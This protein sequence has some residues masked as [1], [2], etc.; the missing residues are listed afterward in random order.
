MAAMNRSQTLLLFVFV[1]LACSAQTIQGN[2]QNGTTGKP[3]P[4]QVKLFTTSG[5]L[6]S[7]TTDD[8]GMFRI[9]LSGNLAPRSLAILKVIHDG[10]EYFQAVNS[11]QFTSVKVYDSSSQVSGIS[12]YLSILQF[13]VKG[14][15][16]QVTE[17]HA[18][19]NASSPPLTRVSP[20][21]LVLSIPE[22]AQVQPATISAPDG[23]KLKL[24]L[25]PIR[26][27]TGKYRIDFPMKPGLT[28]YAIN[29]Q[30]PYNGKLVFR[31]RAQY[32]MRRIGLIVP[33]SMH[34]QSLGAKLFHPA[35][36]QPGTLEQVLDG[37]DANDLFAFELS[38]AGVLSQYFQP[39]NPGETSVAARPKALRAPSS[40]VESLGTN[41]TPTRARS[42]FVGYQMILVI[43]ILVLSGVLLWGM[44]LRRAPRM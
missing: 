15:L 38:G 24:P 10:V 43:G 32:P 31:R 35:A 2:V 34:F 30:V 7:A 17:L 19:N 14:K 12:G 36:G 27:Q 23:G 20:D 37:I 9:E 5:E 29:Y 39:L 11:G 18:F 41:A 25:V 1:S 44:M 22:G 21:N 40:H 28:K 3:E 13:Q 16:L 26:G 8:N 42:R 4:G 33:D 6:A